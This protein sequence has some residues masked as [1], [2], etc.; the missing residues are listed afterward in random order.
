M[1]ADEKE[2]DEAW[3]PYARQ[4]IEESDIEAVVSTLKSE[5]VTQG[6]RVRLFEDAL[7]EFTG[8]HY[9]IAVSSGTAALHLSC[10]GLGL[11]EGDL[12]LV[13]A[14]TF[15][16]TANALRHCGAD[17]LFCDVDAKTGRAGKD[18]FEACLRNSKE[19]ERP[20][21]I[22]LPVSLTGVVP[23]L[24]AIAELAKKEGA[25]LVEDAAHSLG[26]SYDGGNSASCRH[27][28]AA[29]LS[30]HPVKHLCTGEGGAVLTNDETLARRVRRL[31][32]HGIE[33]PEALRESEGPWAYDQRD[34]GWNYRM[35]DIQAS[36][37]TSQL[38]RIGEFLEK[39]R[40]LAKRYQ[41]SLSEGLFSERFDLPEF[42]ENSAWHLYVIRFQTSEERRQAFEFL[43]E[44]RI[45]SQV[46]YRP[47]YRN[48][49]YEKEQ[50]SELPGAEDYYS[51][52]L[53]IPMY[54]S[55]SDRDQ[56]RV[57]EGL[58]QFCERV[59]T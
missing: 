47:L 33:R 3:V 38:G 32:S 44:Q 42:S 59:A 10:R 48:S 41:E 7:C 58:R 39:R 24:E 40:R 43:R 31:R 50:H 13:P 51:G 15:V 20:V 52:C 46:H 14:I 36:L 2:A 55:L 45:Q 12:G 25:Y 19:S 1:S 30:F 18:H 53:S 4:C 56:D 35:T 22:F 57:V 23:D 54:P 17:P 34:L 49:Y 21:R 8:A 9:A 11:R 26:A 29:I 5:Y 37:G 27:S 28:D 16:A 6:P